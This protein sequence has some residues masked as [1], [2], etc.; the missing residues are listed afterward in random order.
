MSR[1]FVTGPARTTATAAALLVTALVTLMASAFIAIPAARGA[2]T[3]RAAGASPFSVPSPTRVEVHFR[4]AMYPAHMRFRLQR[5]IIATVRARA[6]TGSVTW[7]HVFGPWPWVVSVHG[8]LHYQT[9]PSTVVGQLNRNGT[10]S[11]SWFD[12]LRP[13]IPSIW[14]NEPGD[15][16]APV[17]A[18]ATGGITV[19]AEYERD[20]VFAPL[21]NGHRLVFAVRTAPIRLG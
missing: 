16:T 9:P 21:P 11:L 4:P 15:P 12:E 1:T 14:S 5:E 6:A 18:N 20:V 17:P 13:V 8:A 3:G 7:T 2:V 19:V 10:A